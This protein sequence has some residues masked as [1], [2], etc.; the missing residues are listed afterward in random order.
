MQHLSNGINFKSLLTRATQDAQ[1]SHRPATQ[2]GSQ[3]C[4]LIFSDPTLVPRLIHLLEK[5]ATHQVSQQISEKR[6]P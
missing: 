2:Q 3:P 5:D 1:D 6:Y 4:Q